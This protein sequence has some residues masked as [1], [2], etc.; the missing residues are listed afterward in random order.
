MFHEIKSHLMNLLWITWTFCTDSRS[1]CSSHKHTE[2]LMCLPTHHHHHPPTTTP[3]LALFLL[4]QHQNQNPLYWTMWTQN[5]TQSVGRLWCFT[6]VTTV[7]RFWIWPDV[8]FSQ[9]Q[10]CLSVCLPDHC[11]FI[12]RWDC[13]ISEFPVLSSKINLFI[14]H[15]KLLL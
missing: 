6:D 5:L 11:V 2:A 13:N 10:N 4:S 15:M 3:L 7:Y 12:Q 9:N 14:E 1:A 8:W